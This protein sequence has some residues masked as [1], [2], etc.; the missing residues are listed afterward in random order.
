MGS[1]AE[2]TQ[3]SLAMP[4]GDRDTSPARTPMTPIDPAFWDGAARF[5]DRQRFLERRALRSLAEM[6][7]NAGAGGGPLLDVG[8]GTGAMLAAIA[9]SSNPPL[10]ALGVDPSPA[11]LSRVGSL[12]ACWRVERADGR[13]LP[14]E[15]GE[16][17]TVTA[18]YLLHVLEPD[19][20]RAVLTEIRRILRPGGLLGTVT[21]A[22]WGGLAAGIAPA[23]VLAERS[24]GAFAGMRVL[25]PRPDLEAAGL[26]PI[27]ARTVTRG[28]PSLCVVSTR[29]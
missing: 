24:S 17:A 3:A 9:A 22:A 27:A 29:R 5:Y 23:S 21:I 12:P 15:A 18:A 26:E 28:Y 14:F 11:M 1:G 8:T 10:L 25:D 19:D 7:A 2:P 4:E 20:R 6:L 16:F 13:A